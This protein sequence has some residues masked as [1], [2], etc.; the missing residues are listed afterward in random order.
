MEKNQ[1]SEIPKEETIKEKS[2]YQSKEKEKSS[3]PEEE[4]NR[5][6][7]LKDQSSERSASVRGSSGSNSYQNRSGSLLR[8]MHTSE[9]DLDKIIAGK[10]EARLNSNSIE[11]VDD[12][13][14]QKNIESEQDNNDKNTIQ[15]I[16]R[17][18]S[19]RTTLSKDER[20]N[21]FKTIYE[22]KEKDM[23]FK[24]IV[25]AQLNELKENTLSYFAQIFKELENRY[26]EYIN[27]VCDYI[28]NNEIKIN[29]VFQQ[30][31]GSGENILEYTDNNIFIQIG[32]L[33][34][35][36]E[37][38]FEALED[39]VSLLGIFLE[40]PDLIQQKN[41]LEYFINIYSTN[42]LNCWFMNKINFQ[43][44][45]LRSFESN[46]DLSELFSKYLIKKKNN[47]LRN[48]SV[49]QDNKGN[50]S[51]GSD[52]IKQNL[53]IMEKLKFTSVKS[54]DISKVLKFNKK[55]LKD[56]DI[57]V[58]KL[59]SLS[60]IDT[61][62]STTTLSRI[63][64]PSLKKFKIKH[65]IL[66]LSLSGFFDSLLFKSSFLVYLSLQKCFIDDD[67][68]M[69]CFRYLSEK[70]NM[71]ESLQTIS[72]SGNEI[73]TVNM[74]YFMNKNCQF[75]KLE[76]LDFSKN[77]IFEFGIENFKLLQNIKILDL[78]DNNLTNYTFFE[79]IKNQ[80]NINCLLFLCNNMF[81]TN[82]KNNTT[83]Y[84][85]Y[86]NEKL[87][88]YVSKIK[89][90]NLS[91]LFDK[92][93]K[94]K[95]LKLK[96]SPMVKISLIKLNLAYCGLDND[97]VCK[98]LNNNFGL[99]NL[100]I[101]NFSNNFLTL[102]FFELIKTIDLSLEKLT[103]IDLSLNDI[104]SLTIEDY[105]NIEFFINKHLNLKKI[106]LQ[107]TIFLQE[108]LVL[109]QNE[110]DKIGEINKNIMSREVKFIVEKDNSLMIEPL[111]EIFDV[112]DKEV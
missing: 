14:N 36:H 39:H 89:K 59:K 81:L 17:R 18:S 71:I 34:E 82:N 40:K 25:N 1:E 98:F 100:K 90:L 105:Q 70:P 65:T 91:F 87:G 4:D 68:L 32:N 13:E 80:K 110:I 24:D 56:E 112:K 95:L 99:L 83:R 74:R 50:L 29:K 5:K 54:A 23:K 45:N 102:K 96:L 60:I 12:K 61:D 20:R 84:L 35:I 69:Q 53:K 63:Y 10:E 47:N 86:M 57:T 92:V 26:A 7:E 27:N 101:L 104:H 43:K 51:A 15:N 103:C 94:E 37:N 28:D 30:N 88:N 107:E 38:I 72:F 64:T 2:K 66:P 31:T 67:A 109:S 75:K 16:I 22:E 55:D 97:I 78:C 46:K 62:F 11:L 77:C 52:F 41:P 48:F 33:L 85:N 58:S 6:S 9:T 49:T 3:S 79:N 76:V 44:L 93:S 73:S 108:L 8:N 21:L 106:K 19:L 42:I 111:K